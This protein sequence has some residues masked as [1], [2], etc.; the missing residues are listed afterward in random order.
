MS[1]DLNIHRLTS[2]EV[3]LDSS[4]KREPILKWINLI[5]NGPIMVLFI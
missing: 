4:S 5:M 1:K 2:M 3:L